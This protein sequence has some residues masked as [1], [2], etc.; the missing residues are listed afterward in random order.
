MEKPHAIKLEMI[1]IFKL[2]QNEDSSKITEQ[3][4]IM[5]KIVND[6][7]GSMSLPAMMKGRDIMS[8]KLFINRIPPRPC[9]KLL[10]KPAIN[11]EKM[12]W[13]LGINMA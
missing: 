11:G 7:T 4:Y 3:K 1:K 2:W 6:I 9:M 10:V 13:S 8:K 5:V 12:G